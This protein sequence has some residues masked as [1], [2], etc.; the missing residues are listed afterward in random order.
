MKKA[1]LAVALVSAF[2]LA[3]CGSTAPSKNSKE[4]KQTAPKLYMSNVLMD[5]PLY[6]VT[7]KTPS[8][9]SKKGYGVVN[10]DVLPLPANAGV[11]LSVDSTRAKGFD[12]KMNLPSGEQELLRASKDKYGKGVVFVINN[13]SGALTGK[14]PFNFEYKLKDADPSTKDIHS[15]LSFKVWGVPSEQWQG[16]LN[17]TAGNGAWGAA[18]AADAK[19]VTGA[20]QLAQKAKLPLAN[21]WTSVSVKADLTGMKWIFVSFGH[22]FR[23]EVASNQELNDLVAIRKVMVPSP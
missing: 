7:K 18:G 6:S 3:A 17:M 20:Q 16:R 2:G 23:E 22:T 14:L 1:A 21:E 4:N 5:A 10:E 15:M 12:W 19:K 13:T 9:A 11:W 8:G